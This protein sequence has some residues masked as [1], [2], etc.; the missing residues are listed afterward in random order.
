VLPLVSKDG[1]PERAG[2]IYAGLR[3]DFDVTMDV[4]GS[5]GRRY[6][7][8]DELGIPYCITCDYRT[9]EDSTVTLRNRDDCT[10]IRTSIDGLP[11]TLKRLMTNRVN[12][13]AAGEPVK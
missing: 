8:S 3:C 7:R 11:T 12:F 2:E 9:L 4:S 5:I 1:L 10:Q 6:A 13:S